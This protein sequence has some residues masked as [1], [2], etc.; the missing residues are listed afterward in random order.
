MVFQRLL[1]GKHRKLIFWRWEDMKAV[2]G[3]NTGQSNLGLQWKIQI[4][5]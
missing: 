1:I 2:N 5:V 4:K 3:E